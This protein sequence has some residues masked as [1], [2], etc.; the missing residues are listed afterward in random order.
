MPL[1]YV[2]G[3]T[4]SSLW[5]SKVME[6]P[7]FKT[8][9]LDLP[10]F[11]R[12]DPMPGD[13]D[14]H[15]YAKYLKGFIDALGLN[16]PFIAAHSLGGAVAQ[17]LALSFPEILN[18]LVLV[19]SSSPK[20]L[21]TPKDRHPLIEMMR[22]DRSFL[23]K[24]LAATVPTLKDP[25][26]FEAL[27]D[28]AMK[29]AAKA[30]IGNAEALSSFDIFARTSAFTKPVLVLWGKSDYIVTETMARETAEAYPTGTLKVLEGVGHSVIAEDPARFVD[31]LLD[32]T[33]KR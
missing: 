27:V 20:G 23:S 8:Y 4:G 33:A 21:V 29:M 12:S 2:H 32:F 26:F 19:D 18:A 22:K 6:V 30:W 15:R 16:S 17:S 25:A 13:I 31:L 10:N 7:G 11:G 14:L 1:V 5:F 28:D 24:A 9:A 3:N